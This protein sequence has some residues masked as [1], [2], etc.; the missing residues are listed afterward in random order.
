MKKYFYMSMLI[1]TG[2]IMNACSFTAS[3][4][5]SDV[6]EET[7]ALVPPGTLPFRNPA[8]PLNERIND[9]LSRLTIK[10]KA[11]MMVANAQGVPHLKVPSYHFW[12]ECLHGVARAGDATVFPQAIGMAAT[13]D[14]PLIHKVADTISTEARAKYH[15][16]LRKGKRERYRGL[17]FW[18]PNIN[19]FR[20][21]RW[22]RGQETYGED[23][24]LSG[25]LAVAFIHGIQG[26]NPKYYKALA[27]AK[28]YAVHNGPEPSRHV[29]NAEPSKQDLYDTYLPQFERAVV[30]GKV[31]SVMGAYNSVYGKPSCAS[32]FLLQTILRD[33][34]GFKG[35]VVS[36][37][38]AIRDIYKN[39][40]FTKTPEEAV[41]VAI[42]AG[43]DLNCGN[44]YGKYIPAAVQKGLLTEK[45][46]D[47]ALYRLLAT[48][49]RLGMF[50]PPEMVPYA[51]IP[52]S[53]NCTA[54]NRNLALLTAEK[55][56]VMLKND[57]T[58]PLKADKL[59]KIAVIGPNAEPYDILLG[60]YH[61]TSSKYVTILQ[62][63]QNLCKGKAEVTYTSGCPLVSGKWNSKKLKNEMTKAVKLAADADTIIFVGGIDSHL[64]G[65]EKKNMKFPGFKGGDRVTI[66]LPEVQVDLLKKLKSLNK[67]LI[68]VNCSGSAIAI[69]WIADNASAVLQAWYPGEEGGTA[70]ANVIFGKYNPAGRLP[71][72]FYRSTNDLPPF[73]D[74]SM[75]NRTYRYFTGTPLYAFGYGMSYS[76]FKY[77]EALLKK[78]TVESD[79]TVKL[80]VK[81]ENVS[82]MNGEEVVQVYVRV[83]G[84]ET[85]SKPKK[86]LCAFNRVMIPAGQIK[87]VSFEIPVK[88]FRLWNDKK[89]NYAVAK[90]EYTLEIGAASDDVRKQVKLTVE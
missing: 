56:I 36:D 85:S 2:V 79:D 12:N 23:P 25:E 49:F 73:E 58:L 6:K 83:P 52:Y 8:L 46:L 62:G 75:K 11:K 9:L 27:C 28:H 1:I 22:G 41:A 76:N 42:K 32:P 53:A 84:K 74:Y 54:E 31:G 78:I 59:K 55:S 44:M 33:N 63:L 19:I 69:P 29:F 18:T 89:N 48:R 38:G 87:T 81:I 13:W 39:H 51:S 82:P 37:C 47:K 45:D 16:A 7:A 43:C 72:T 88:R 34:W 21:P 35:H 65:E 17:T 50:D 61:G 66:E 64:E 80:D 71:V 10:E 68:Y 4:I 30:D 15:E 57:G 70:V 24:F 26:S 86:T 90:G 3:G 60:N 20:D 40:K 77:R 5:K 67:P 14:T